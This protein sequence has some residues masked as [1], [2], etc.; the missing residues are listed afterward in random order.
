MPP[1][2]NIMSIR[3]ATIWEWCDAITFANGYA[4]PNFL[5]LNYADMSKALLRSD[6]RTH[7]HSKVKTSFMSQPTAR[8]KNSSKAASRNH[9]RAILPYE[10]RTIKFSYP[11]ESNSATKARNSRPNPEQLK[12]SF[13]KLSESH[14]ATRPETKTAQ[15]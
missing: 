8:V 14:S 9:L 10:P 2:S 7:S 4:E 13:Q 11:S 15:N 3:Y 6:F 5:V 12:I 1:S